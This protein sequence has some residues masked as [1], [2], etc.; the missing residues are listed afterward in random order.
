MRKR[1]DFPNVFVFSLRKQQFKLPFSSKCIQKLFKDK[2]IIRFHFEHAEPDMLIISELEFWT[3]LILTSQYLL[4]RGVL[5]EKFPI[6]CKFY[7]TLIMPQLGS[8]KPKTLSTSG[9]SYG[10]LPKG[11]T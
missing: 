11:P 8:E 9:D 7:Y 1:W 10:H 2:K 4:I 6:S 5:L 3:V